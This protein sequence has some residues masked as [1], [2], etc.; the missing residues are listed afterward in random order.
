MSYYAAD[1]NGY[2]DDVASVGGMRDF[3]NWAKTQE[4]V[5]RQFVE[6]GSTEQI[7]ELADALEAA[8]AEGSVAS[9]RNN[10]VEQARKAQEVFI[11]SDGNNGE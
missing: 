8:K 9:T 5:I 7:T 11:L 3:R 10:L 6:R 2:L 4:P 1:A